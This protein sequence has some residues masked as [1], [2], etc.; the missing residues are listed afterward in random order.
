[1]DD[2]SLDPE[3]AAALGDVLRAVGRELADLGRMA[4]ELQAVVGPPAPAG[5]P[6]GASLYRLQTLD[7]LTQALHG[8]SDFLC[9]LAPTVPAH[10]LCDPARAARAVSLSDLARRLS[11]SAQGAASPPDNGAGELELFGG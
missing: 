4:S 1:M 8:A 3:A 9:A 10:W 7:I 11:C 5:G 2:E 6:D